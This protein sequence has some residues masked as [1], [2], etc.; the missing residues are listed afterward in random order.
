MAM[1]R[2]QSRNSLAGSPVR[3][4]ILQNSRRT[5]TVATTG[6]HSPAMNSSPA[7]AMTTW[8]KKVPRAGVFGENT[9]MLRASNEPPAATLSRRSPTPG[10]PRANDENSRCTPDSDSE[11]PEDQAKTQKD[12]PGSLFR[13]IKVR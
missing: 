9:R 4:M 5:I 6:V 1:P 10:Q 7:T 11:S 13:V 8:R 12:W 3:E 2:V